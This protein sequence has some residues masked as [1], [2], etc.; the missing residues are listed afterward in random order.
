MIV[1]SFKSASTT[2]PLPTGSTI[3]IVG[4][5]V[6]DPIAILAASV[7]KIDLISLLRI[8]IFDAP[9][10]VSLLTPLILIAVISVFTV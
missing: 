9:I 1:V 4:G 6:K 3:S 10:S 5:V 2:H 8:V 7:I